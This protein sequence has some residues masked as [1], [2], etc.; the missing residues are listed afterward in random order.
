MPKL[1]L[2]KFQKN[3]VHNKLQS[4]LNLQKSNKKPH[5]NQNKFNRKM[6]FLNQQRKM[7]TITSNTNRNHKN[8]HM[9]TLTVLRESLGMI[10]SLRSWNKHK[11]KN[12]TKQVQ[13]NIPISKSKVLKLSTK[14]LLFQKLTVLRNKFHMDQWI[15]SDLM[16]SS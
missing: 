13:L 4:K 15:F 6:R 14:R 1:H 7:K 2:S 5:K 8:S 10:S 9:F 16:I 11:F 12:L 3:Q